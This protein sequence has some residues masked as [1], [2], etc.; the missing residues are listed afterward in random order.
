MFRGVVYPLRTKFLS[1]DQRSATA[2]KIVQGET[3]SEVLRRLTLGDPEDRVSFGQ[4]L[5]ALGERGFG[6][7]LILF[8]V[9]NL[10]PFPGVPGVSFVTGM[11]ILVI[12]VQ[13]ILARDEP[14][15][16]A[17]VAARASAAPSSR[18]SS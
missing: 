7:L 8:A 2:S 16:P 12:A 17:W 5:D 18:N 13:L 6:L 4:M 1:V 10:L 11:A 15:F 14:A 3:A 9:P